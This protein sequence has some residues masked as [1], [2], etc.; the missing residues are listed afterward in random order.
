MLKKLTSNWKIVTAV[1][2][3]VVFCVTLICQ[4]LYK[5]VDNYVIA[6]ILNKLYDADNYC[7]FVSPALS[8]IVGGLSYISSAVDWFTFL[9]IVGAAVG[10]I[11][12][13]YLYVRHGMRRMSLAN[14]ILLIPCLIRLPMKISRL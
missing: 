3:C 14:C 2:I 13:V 7:M 10:F 8:W 5:N 12:M 9:C 4:P 6:M 11:W 1:T